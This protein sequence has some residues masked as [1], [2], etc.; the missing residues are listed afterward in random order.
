M[1]AEVGIRPEEV[2][3]DIPVTA[4]FTIL[5]ALEPQNCLADTA[6]CGA[7]RMVI[8]IHVDLVADPLVADFT[9]FA[10]CFVAQEILLDSTLWLRSD[11]RNFRGGVM[12]ISVGFNLRKCALQHG[13]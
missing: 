13:I 9:D 7:I 6:F 1:G 5:S 12:A 11:H 4:T 3:A 8:P 2:L 10:V